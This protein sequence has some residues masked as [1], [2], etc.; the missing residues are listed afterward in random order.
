MEE[1]KIRAA[2]YRGLIG[3]QAVPVIYKTLGRSN[4]LKHGR[5]RARCS[6]ADNK[7]SFAA[8]IVVDAQMC[9]PGVS[10]GDGTD[11]VVE[12][13]RKVAGR[14]HEANE[15]RYHEVPHAGHRDAVSGYRL[16]GSPTSHIL[17]PDLE[18]AETRDRNLGPILC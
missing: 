2:N 18:G 9:Q 8:I 11:R 5:G 17:I 14:Q 7:D 12:G 1:R 15:L 16:P 4:S 13:E 10:F 3:R 6:A